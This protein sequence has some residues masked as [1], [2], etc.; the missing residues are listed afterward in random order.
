[1][2]AV[3]VAIA[4]LCSC[5]VFA[6]Q[7]AFP[8]FIPCSFSMLLSSKIYNTQKE[9]VATSTDKVIR[10]NSADA[11]RW[12]SDF[13][14]ITGVLDPQKWIIIWRP[15]LGVSYHDLGEKCLKNNGR[16]KMCPRPYDWICEKTDG[17]T[18]FRQ[19]STWEGL[20][21]FNWYAHFYVN[22]YGVPK[23]EMT[24]NVH[25]LEDGTVVLINGTAKNTLVDLT[26]VM[27]VQYYEHNQEFR[28]TYFIPSAHCTNGS[29]IGALPEST[30][31]F[32]KQCYGSEGSLASRVVL[33]WAV[34][35]MLLVAVVMF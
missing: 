4:A 8:E 30:E 31:A 9:L 27:E 12:E 5:A 26:Y 22:E 2:R 10:D 21:A 35:L 3:F 20:N 28:P 24:A 33:S 16:P 14:G 25:V 29:A 19:K 7:C 11:W 6:A 13:S 17:L 18:W 15:D 23:T 34:I 32:Q 1:M